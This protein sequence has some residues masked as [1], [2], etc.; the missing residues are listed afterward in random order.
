MILLRS[1]LYFVGLIVT[2]IVFA[3]PMFT[4]GLLLPQKAVGLIA[5][6][7][8]RSN[9]WLLKYICRLD[10]EVHGWEENF[11]QHNAII[12]AKHQ[13][14]WE[15]IAL[16]GILPPQ[17]AWIL[18]RELMWIPLFGWALA[19]SGAISIDRSAGRR[20]LHQIIE[21]GIKRLRTGAWVI[22]FPEGTRT[23]PGQRRK[24]GIG[25]AMLA[26]KSGYPVIPIAHNAGV[27]WRRRSL[28]K[29]PGTIQVV[30]GP[31]IQSKGRSAA[32]INREVEEWIES[33]VASLPQSTEDV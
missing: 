20:A 26:E 15:T 17:Q 33:T 22:I 4:I 25:G 19:A 10:Y 23:A 6:A 8:G 28:K 7:W 30:I 29:Y 32:E 3:L 21:Q 16:R 18:K 9:L 1:L 27:F 12:M 11:P 14:S 2:V 24:Y 13:S 5:N 31:P